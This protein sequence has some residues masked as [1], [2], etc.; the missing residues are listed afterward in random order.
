M[1]EPGKSILKHSIMK[2]SILLIGLMVVVGCVVAGILNHRQPVTPQSQVT[3]TVV[4]EPVPTAPVPAAL[5]PE[6][7]LDAQ[8]PP[9]ITQPP[10]P[11]PRSAQPTRRPTQVAAEP[12][13]PPRP[14]STAR[15]QRQLQDPL[16]R[17]ALAFVGVDPEAE[18]Y[19]LEAIFDPSLPNG[20][21]RED[22]ME[23]LNE[24]GFEDP[25]HPGPDD[26]PLIVSRLDLIEE[27]AASGDI[28]DFMIEHLAEAYKDL[29]NMYLQASL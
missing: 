19:W 24:V 11:E 16:A 26:L 23:D 1:L 2:R 14:Q 29:A 9:A 25:H 5:A 22:L 7:V 17:V 10:E 12:P 20:K 6:P 28:D 21:E 15:P 4:Q 8:S 27:V 18:E 13:P 3:P